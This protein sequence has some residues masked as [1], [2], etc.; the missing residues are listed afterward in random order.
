MVSFKEK[1]SVILKTRKVFKNWYLYPLVYLK[2]T[3]KKHIIFTTKTGLK[4]KLRVDSTDLMALTHVWLM[5]EYYNNDFKINN[6]DIVIDVGA[7]I[8]LFS[9]YASQYCKNGKIFCFEPIKEN[10][11]LLISNIKLNQIENI[12]PFNI[13]IS[14][15]SSIVKIYL[16][17]DE[18]GHSMFI[19]TSSSIEVRATTLQKILED[20]NIKKCNFLKLDCEGAEYT[21]IDSLSQEFIKKVEKIII[22]YHFADTKPQLLKELIKKLQISS[23]K[24]TTRKIFSD[25]GFLYG[26]NQQSEC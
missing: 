4:I 24:I 10:F 7:H 19:P 11:E 14:N 12:I 15:D 3:S 25:I 17:K 23:F 1:I 26:I 21:I 2:L 9:L 8:G 13:A 6:N 22:E 16:N 5:K 18:A 20:N